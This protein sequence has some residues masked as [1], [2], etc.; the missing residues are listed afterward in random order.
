MSIKQE[1]TN[2]LLHTCLTPC[3]HWHITQTGP[4]QDKGGHDFTY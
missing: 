4:T 3:Q 1:Q 2:S